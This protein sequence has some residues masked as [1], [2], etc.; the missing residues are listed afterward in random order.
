MTLQ[1][2]KNSLSPSLH[3]F[4]HVL[5][6]KCD[7]SPSA[8]RE[9]SKDVRVLESLSACVKGRVYL[10]EEGILTWP[11]KFI[12]PEHQTSDHIQHFREVVRWWER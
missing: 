10:S 4:S 1:S 11:V 8:D 2:I 7:K 3:S 5:V 12:Y 9:G 6:T